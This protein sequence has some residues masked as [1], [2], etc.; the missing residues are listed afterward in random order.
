MFGTFLQTDNDS[1]LADCLKIQQGFAF[2]STEFI[3]D[4]VPIIKIGTVNKGF[5]D[6]STLSFIADGYSEKIGRYEIVPGDLLISLTGT[7]G[8]D[9][10]GNTCF[11][12]KDSIYPVYLLNQ[13]VGKLVCRKNV[14]N[15]YFIDAFMKLPKVKSALIKQNRGVR[16]ANLSNS[17]IY[18]IQLSIPPI[19]LQNQF[20]AIVEKV[21]G[22]KSR[23]QQSLT[24]LANLYGALSQKGFK[25]EL[26]LSRV[27]LPT[28]GPDITEVE[29]PDVE[30][31]QPIEPLFELPAPEELAVLQ[32]TEGRKFLL[33]EWLNAW[34]EQLGDTLFTSQAFMEAARQRLW[35]LAEDDAPDWGVAEYDELKKW[36]FK[37]IEE[38]KLKQTRKI[39]CANGKLQFGNQVI[40]RARKSRQ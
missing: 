9:D 39:I 14:A 25:G 24:D 30:E 16:Q 35:E 7:V 10:Y 40:L 32:T 37:H 33:G 29:L 17:D 5:F 36:L 28:E 26:D 19:E 31:I 15:P 8:K 1:T 3:E 18:N 23:Y 22:L 12:P 27:V 20:A 13:R 4:G 11:V 38:G 21:E 34:L 2:K 6:Y